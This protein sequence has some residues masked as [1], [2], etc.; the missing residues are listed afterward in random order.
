MTNKYYNI[1][2]GLLIVS[3]ARGEEF[4]NRSYDKKCNKTLLNFEF[5]MLSILS[6]TSYS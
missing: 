5:V 2:S 1:C 4:E 3:K 6:V